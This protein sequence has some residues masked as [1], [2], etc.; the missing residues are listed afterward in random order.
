MLSSGVSGTPS[1]VPIVQRPRTWP[2]QGQDTGSNPVGDAILVGFIPERWV[3]PHSGDIG[4]T[5][6]PKGSSIGSSWGAYAERDDAPGGVLIAFLIC[7][8]ATALAAWIAN[9]P[10]QSSPE[11]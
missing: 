6:G 9:R 4:N 5:F 1:N 7:L 11:T 3:T 10:H 8:A 2:F